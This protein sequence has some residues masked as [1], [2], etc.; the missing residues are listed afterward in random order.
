[1]KSGEPV[2]DYKDGVWLVELRRSSIGAGG[3]RVA[4]VVGVYETAEQPLISALPNALRQR[5]LLLV[6]TTASMCDACAQL[7]DGLLRTCPDPR[8]GDQS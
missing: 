6:W 5:D 1:M 3:A 8:A 4:A 7:V 2:D